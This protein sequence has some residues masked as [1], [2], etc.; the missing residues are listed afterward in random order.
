MAALSRRAILNAPPQRSWAGLAEHE[1]SSPAHYALIM[2]CIKDMMAG[3][4]PCVSTVLAVV[5][6]LFV[7]RCALR[8]LGSLFMT[9]LRPGKKLTKFGSWAVVTGATGKPSSSAQ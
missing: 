7:A 8:V 2:D 4:D 9:F 5:G 1:K 6:G 3:V